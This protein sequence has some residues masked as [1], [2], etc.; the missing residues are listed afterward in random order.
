MAGKGYWQAIEEKEKYAKRLVE[1]EKIIETLNAEE[2]H[3]LG[4]LE[5]V[6]QHI[7]YYEKL[8]RDM[9]KELQPATISSLL[10]SI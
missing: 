6:K 7:L 4:E 9:K 8:T 3:I 2:E 10:S 1:L 5:K